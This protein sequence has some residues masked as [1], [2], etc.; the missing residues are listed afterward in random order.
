ML[1]DGL[2]IKELLLFLKNKKGKIYVKLSF[3]QKAPPTSSLPFD[4]AN[5][6]NGERGCKSRAVTK[7]LKD[8]IIPEFSLMKKI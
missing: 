6:K 4:V 2:K 1:I 7:F 5:P 8:E 3:L